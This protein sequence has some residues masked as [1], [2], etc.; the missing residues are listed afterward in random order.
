MRLDIRIPI[1]LLFIVLG[2]ILTVYGPLAGQQVYD[3]HSLGINVNFWWGLVML[4]FGIFMFVMGRRGT[5]AVR[6]TQ[7]SP[8]GRKLEEIEGRREQEGGLGPRG[9]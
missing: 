3:D 6:S 5:S 4:A 7:D 2:V 9:H 1:G 8:E